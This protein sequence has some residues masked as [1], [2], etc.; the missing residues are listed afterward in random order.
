METFLILAN[1]FGGFYSIYLGFISY[2]RKK[3]SVAGSLY[4]GKRAK[5]LS[6]LTILVGVALLANLARIYIF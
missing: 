5:Y 2:Q 6:S 4:Q 3:I 1:L